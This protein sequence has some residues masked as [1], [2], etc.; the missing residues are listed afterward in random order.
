M[1]RVVVVVQDWGILSIHVMWAQVLSCAAPQDLPSRNPRWKRCLFLAGSGKSSL[2]A[3]AVGAASWVT[4]QW[5]VDYMSTPP[6]HGKASILAV[7]WPV[8][9]Y[10][11]TNY[12][13]VYSSN[14]AHIQLEYLTH[15]WRPSPVAL[16][17]FSA[18]SSLT[19][20]DLNPHNETKPGILLWEHSQ[21]ITESCVKKILVS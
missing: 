17:W 14:L 9:L 11:E 10:L 3:E 18:Q 8:W 6:F 15:L 21:P 5:Y 12:G 16:W 19:T 7:N 1:R 20:R 13:Y 4:S 2:T